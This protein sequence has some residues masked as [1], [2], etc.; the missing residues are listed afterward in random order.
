LVCS[1]V[2]TSLLHGTEREICFEYKEPLSNS[3]NLLNRFPV[4]IRVKNRPQLITCLLK[5]IPVP[6]CSVTIQQISRSDPCNKEA[7]TQNMSVEQNSEFAFRSKQKR[8]VPYRN[9]NRLT[10]LG[11][12]WHGYIF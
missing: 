12:I 5:R 4:P 11:E 6:F 8:N 7:S 1:K 10:N 9:P 2:K 3:N